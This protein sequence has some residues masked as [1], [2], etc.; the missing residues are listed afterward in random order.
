MQF[1]NLYCEC[2]EDYDTFMS[3]LRDRNRFTVHHLN[4][5]RLSR[6]DKFERFV[7][8][9]KSLKARPEI[10]GISETWFTRDE[11]GENSDSCQPISLYQIQGYHAEF[12]SRDSRSAGVAIYL[13]DEL[14]YQVLRKANGA[15]SFVHLKVENIYPSREEVYVTCVYM[16]KI[17]DHLQLFSVLEELLA[18]SRGKK[19]ILIGDFNIDLRR[20]SAIGLNYMDLLG[21]YDFHVSND[22][23]TRPVSG[24]LIDHVICNF[25]PVL[26]VTVKNE[27]SDHNGTFSLF[28]C[29]VQVRKRA[30]ITKHFTD[31]REL[32]ERLITVFAQE[33][34]YCSMQPENMINFLVDSVRMNVSACTQVRTYQAKKIDEKPSVDRLVIKLS[35]AK[36][37]LL[38]KR[39]KR[40]NDPRLNLKL[41]ELSKKIAD[42]KKMLNEQQIKTKMSGKGNVKD[43]WKELNRILGRKKAATVIARLENKQKTAVLTEKREIA[44]ELNNYFACV[45]KELSDAIPRQQTRSLP[46]VARAGRSMVLFPTDR[47]EIRNLLLG[48]N[49]NKSTGLDG[50]SCR[51]L[52][53]CAE[54]ISKILTC[55]IQKIFET[56]VYPESLKRAKVTPIFKGGEK[57]RLGNYRPISI[58]PCL[59]KIVEKTL[60]KRIASFLL[61]TGFVTGAQYGF[62]VRCSTSTAAL[63][64]LN[65]V[66]GNLDKRNVGVVS[67]L[68]LDLSKAFDTV[69]HRILLDLCERAGLRGPVLKLLADYLSGRVQVVSLDGVMSD[70]KTVNTGVP[71]G[72][73]LGPTL[74]LIYING[75]A[76][77]PLK[78]K[79]FMFADDTC[80]FYAGT[81]DVQNCL[82]MNADLLVLNEFFSANLLTLNKEKTKYIHL[83]SFAKKLKL[84]V[85]VVLNGVTLQRVE[86][87]EFLGLTIDSHLTWRGHCETVCKRVRPAVAAIFRLQRTLPRSALWQIYFAFVH[88]HLSYMV[89]VWGLAAACHLKPV[90]VLQSRALKMV[91]GVSMLTSSKLLYGE[92]VPNVL[93][94]KGLNYLNA[95]K[96]VKQVLNHEVHHTVVIPLRDIGRTLRNTRLLHSVQVIT[97]FGHNQICHYGPKLFHK[98]PTP[99][100][101]I[102]ATNKFVLEVKKFLKSP[103]FIDN[104][105]L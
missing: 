6:L 20:C 67:G 66:Y 61:K 65:F 87:F 34:L 92:L 100:Q 93:P 81:D 63:E 68:G 24:T 54:P 77:A 9:V 39:R 86:N 82:D 36:K 56:G 51:V 13:K 2:V 72:S 98:L 32:N 60:N 90:Q 26:N 88:S 31:F 25:D 73:V 74:F 55:C 10:L 96:F 102:P 46:L 94:V 41:K 8:Y 91:L 53:N 103:G 33:E 50:I 12:C 15:V 28:E 30:T 38:A 37:R 17:C 14:E 11:T 79:L 101:N 49:V 43:K 29:E 57:S 69:D 35:Q 44:E 104:I 22:R 95:C 58:L 59:N 42:R 52:K 75:L 47:R 80:L 27:L 99:V 19:H 7:E 78:G 18:S 45:G 97:N 3:V 84:T 48:L 64:L 21:S 105:I 71:Q 85:P 5:Q 23:V 16:P 70:F 76:S 83:H 40:P 89:E 4:V 62:R 1:D